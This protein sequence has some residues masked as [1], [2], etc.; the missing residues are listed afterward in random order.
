MPKAKISDICN[1]HFYDVN[2]EKQYFLLIDQIIINITEHF[3][4]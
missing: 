3:L 4:V 1:L 2:L